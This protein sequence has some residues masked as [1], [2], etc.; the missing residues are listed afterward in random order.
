MVEYG[1][2]QPGHGIDPDE[3]LRFVSTVYSYLT[4]PQ[5]FTFTPEFMADTWRLTLGEGFRPIMRKAASPAEDTMVV[6]M[7]TGTFAVLGGLRAAGYWNAIREECCGDASPL[8][9]YGELDAE[10]WAGKA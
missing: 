6:R 9:P 10:F 8:T 7:G 4:Q 2:L 5:P 1:S 3:V